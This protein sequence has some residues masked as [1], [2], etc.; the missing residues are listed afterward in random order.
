MKFQFTDPAT[1]FSNGLIVIK[2][3]HQSLIQHGEKLLLLIEEIK[4][5]GMNEPLA[6]R[7]IEIHCFYYHASRLHHL[8][9]EQVLFPLIINHSQLHKGMADLLTQ[10]HEEI[11]HLW[12]L[13]AQMLGK[14]EQIGNNDQLQTV[15]TQ[16]EKKQREHLNREEE[17]FLPKIEL[18][19]SATQKLQAGK[20]MAALRH[21]TLN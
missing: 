14:P 11:E 6:N 10:D 3:Y 19:L 4:Q 16:F 13:L 21:L 17:D 2:H 15:A 7:C 1:D 8:D 20:Q 9:E 12:R 5:Q 18:L